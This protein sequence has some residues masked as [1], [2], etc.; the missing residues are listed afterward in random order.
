MTHPKLTHAAQGVAA[1]L[2]LTTAT[3]KFMGDPGSVEVFV[4]L[5]MEPAG[6]YVIA[7]LELVAALLLLSPLAALGSVIAVAVMCG[8]TIAHLTQLGLQIDSNG[9]RLVGMLVVV[10]CCAGY[11]LVERR[12][13]LPLVGDTL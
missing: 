6:R 13:E 1:L 11:V 8:A 3:M 2:L 10:L 7:V 12:R 5:D 4:I 9:G